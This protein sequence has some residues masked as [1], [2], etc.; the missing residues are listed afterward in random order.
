MTLMAEYC[1][2]LPKGTDK[3]LIFSLYTKNKDG[4]KVVFGLNG[5][6]CAMQ[7]R[8]A[9]YSKT[10][11][12]SFTTANGKI[13]IDADKGQISI[14]FD[15]ES[16]EKYPTGTLV[17]DIELTNSAGEVTRPISGKIKVTPEVTKIEPTDKV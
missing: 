3:T 4:S 17:Y 13:T 8:T 6:G 2:E 15:H 5:F 12:D 9:Y 1:F 10:A 14:K 16:T 7:I 11:V